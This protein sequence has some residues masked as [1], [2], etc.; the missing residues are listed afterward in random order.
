MASRPRILI[1]SPHAGET[2][3]LADWIRSEGFEPV[4]V[5]TLSRAAEQIRDH[6]FD[7][8]MSD[9]TFAFKSEPQLLALVRG[10]NA[11][12]PII[13]IGEND[14]IAESQATTRNVTYLTRP[15]EQTSVTC[16]VAM[17]VMETRPTRRSLRK[18][19][20]RFDAIV[21]GVP[22]HIIDI[23]KEGLRLEIPRSRKSAPPP[24]HFTVRV[25]ML[26][27]GVELATDVD[28]GRAVGG[29]RVV[30][31]GAGWQ[32]ARGRAGVARARWTRSRAR[33]PRSSC[34]EKRGTSSL[35][36][37][38]QLPTVQFWELVVGVGNTRLIANLCRHAPFRTRSGSMRAARRAGTRQAATAIVSTSSGTT[39]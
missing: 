5:Q 14:P 30:R 4:P 38:L 32:Y 28:V 35:N 19:V 7:L 15:L 24:P 34:I 9:F 37:Q 11:K 18:P 10:R 16:S 23:S 26:A 12:T 1:A 2:P 3:M 29:S 27:R 22:S 31:R 36:P 20:N 39:A 25:P 6:A 33:A 13:A 17:A 8:F 21:D